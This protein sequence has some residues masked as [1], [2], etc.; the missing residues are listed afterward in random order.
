MRELEDLNQAIF[1]RGGAIQTVLNHDDCFALWQCYENPV[2]I[3]VYPCN[4]GKAWGRLYLDDGW[5][6]SYM[7]GGFSEFEFTFSDNVLSQV[8]IMSGYPVPES[9][10]IVSFKFYGIEERPTNV[11]LLGEDVQSF[12]Y[13]EESKALTVVGDSEV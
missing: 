3:E 7:D 9:K 11:K 12:Q 5:S 2:T 1:V 6:N 10:S 4:E 13:S 8:T